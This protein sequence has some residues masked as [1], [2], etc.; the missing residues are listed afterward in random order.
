MAGPSHQRPSPLL[1][2]P[3]FHSAPLEGTRH[4]LVAQSVKSLSAK[5][6]TWVQPWVTKIPLGKGL[7]THSRIPAWRI[8]W[9]GRG[10]VGYSSWGRKESDPTE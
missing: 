4:S 10:L 2:I 1:L 3:V 6:E 7:T 5:P 8:P 9:V